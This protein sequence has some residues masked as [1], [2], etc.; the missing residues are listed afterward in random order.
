M[1][2][3]IHVSNIDHSLYRSVI[4]MIQQDL[5]M[6]MRLKYC[7]YRLRTTIIFIYHKFIMRIVKNSVKFYDKNL[8]GMRH[9]RL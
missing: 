5:L 4:Y 1:N 3:I 9:Y 7:S 6:M 2:Q 8:Q